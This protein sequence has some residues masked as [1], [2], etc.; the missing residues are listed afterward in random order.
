MPK[1]V[2]LFGVV[3]I[4]VILIRGLLDAINPKFLWK[5]SKGWKAT[6]EPPNSY[7]ISIRIFGIGSVILASLLFLLPYIIKR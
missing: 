7:F 4:M 2:I 1:G 6:K 3:M 5:I